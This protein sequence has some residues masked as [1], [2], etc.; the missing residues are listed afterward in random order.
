MGNRIELY[1]RIE[2][3][4]TNVEGMEQR[5]LRMSGWEHTCNTHGSYWM[6]EKKCDGRTLQVVTSTAMRI[7][8]NI[9][10]VDSL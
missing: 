10:D 7:Q 5:F 6:W 4:K 3:A 8:K 2:Q 9:D 1:E